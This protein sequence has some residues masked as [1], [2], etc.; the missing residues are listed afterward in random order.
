MDETT[1]KIELSIRDAGLLIGAVEGL[2]SVMSPDNP[3]LARLQKLKE[4][5]DE[6][7]RDAIVVVAKC[8]FREE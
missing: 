1:I 5:L 2:E 8:T 6:K 7:V 3:V 4:R